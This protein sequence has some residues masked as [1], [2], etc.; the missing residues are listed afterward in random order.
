MK[1]FKNVVISVS[2]D[3]KCLEELLELKKSDILT[4][5]D[6]IY[7]VHIYGKESEVHVPEDVRNHG[8][9]EIEKFILQKLHSLAESLIPGHINQTGQRHSNCLFNTCAKIKILSYSQCQL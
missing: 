2:L 5:A 4:Y 1:R 8:Y 3:S 9:E 7:F 6:N